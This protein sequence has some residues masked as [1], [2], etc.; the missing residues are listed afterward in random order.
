MYEK[1]NHATNLENRPRWRDWA[2]GLGTT[3]PRLVDGKEVTDRGGMCSY[4][5]L[6]LR[7]AST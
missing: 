7:V 3:L 2:R 5:P 1:I 4:R 6:R